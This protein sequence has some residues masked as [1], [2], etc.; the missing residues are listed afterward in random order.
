MDELALEKGSRRLQIINFVGVA[1]TL[2][3][4]T[5]ALHKARIHFHTN[6]SYAPMIYLRPDEKI[7]YNDDM[8][9][10][11]LGMYV[12]DISQFDM[13]R[14]TAIIDAIVWFLFDP[15]LTSVNSFKGFTF[16]KSDLVKCSEPRISLVG[17]QIL[18]SFDIKL[19]SNFLLNYA[20][21]PLNNHRLNLV[22]EWRDLSP[23][24]ADFVVNRTDF[25]LNPQINLS[26]WKIVDKSVAAGYGEEKMRYTKQSEQQLRPRVLFAFDITKGSIRETYSLLLPLLLMFFVAVF[27]LLLDPMGTLPVSLSVTS[28][29]A[30]IA[31]RFVLDNI[32]PKVNYPIISD[33]L[34]TY[35]LGMCCLIFFINIFG[36]YISLRVKGGITIVLYGVTG[37]LLHLIISTA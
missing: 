12:R 30:L 25:R 27:T 32:S 22:M 28:I 3:V 37:V 4:V 20:S 10:V 35:F 17:D 9:V 2:L 13:V 15:T 14:G 19:Q 1:F 6:D 8:P 29:S 31:Y 7:K 26:G 23:A 18:A 5:F 16:D 36:K 11:H 24:E 34:Y 21:Y 33:N